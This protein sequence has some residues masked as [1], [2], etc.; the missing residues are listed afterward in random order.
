MSRRFHFV[1]FAGCLMLTLCS[2]GEDSRP[3]ERIPVAEVT[4]NTTEITTVA[5]AT[6]VANV[7][8]CNDKACH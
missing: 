8:L 7:N 2:C 6:T 3:S 4:Q 5:D 1:I